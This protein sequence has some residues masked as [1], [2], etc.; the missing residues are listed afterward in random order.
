MNDIQIDTN[1]NIN[2]IN[3]SGDN[4]SIPPSS[5]QSADNSSI[6][7][8]VELQMKQLSHAGNDMVDDDNKSTVSATIMDAAQQ[9][10]QIVDV[11]RVR[12]RTTRHYCHVGCSF[13]YTIKDIVT[14]DVPLTPSATI[15][16]P[17]CVN[18]NSSSTPINVDVAVNTN[19]VG[20]TTAA[21]ILNTPDHVVIRVFDSNET[22]NEVAQWNKREQVRKKNHKP[23]CVIKHGADAIEKLKEAERIRKQKQ[24]G[25]IKVEVPDTESDEEM[26]EVPVVQK[27]KTVKRNRTSNSK[28]AT[29]TSTPAESNIVSDGSSAESSA[30]RSLRSTPAPS[31]VATINGNTP[32][33]VVPTINLQTIYNELT[34]MMELDEDSLIESH[35]NDLGFSHYWHHISRCEITHVNKFNK[36]SSYTS[37]ITSTLNEQS[38]AIYRNSPGAIAPKPGTALPTVNRLSNRDDFVDER[39]ETMV[40]QVHVDPNTNSIHMAYRVHGKHSAQVHD[41]EFSK[42]FNVLSG[43][44]VDVTS[45]MNGDSVWG[46]QS[47]NCGAPPHIDYIDNICDCTLGGKI[48]IMLHYK[49]CIKNKI[50]VTGPNGEDGA[51]YYRFTSWDNILLCDSFRWFILNAGETVAFSH[52]YVHATVSIP[53]NVMSHTWGRC[54]ATNKSIIRVVK[55]FWG[56]ERHVYINHY[57]GHY[58]PQ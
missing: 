43:D 33:L 18:R 42:S 55:E 48:F 20:T 14:N 47:M 16:P 13:Y 26:L 58:N 3:D 1:M 51:V 8:S 37:H 56:E 39:N 31:A 5:S 46:F 50:I 38:I 22:V 29:I 23:K 15:L 57:K 45:D 6:S 34:T 19:V 35:P 36:P 40:F 9:L 24:R 11:V 10:S 28:A 25:T 53:K 7:S 27:R 49:E 17:P 54:A 32:H 41:I 12:V 52:A 4:Q 21:Q 2:P 30:H 44:V